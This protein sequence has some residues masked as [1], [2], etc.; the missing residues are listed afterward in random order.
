MALLNNIIEALRHWE[1]WRRIEGTP[2]R[3]DALERRVADLESKLKRS[4]GEACPACGELG[5]RVVR[6]E[7]MPEFAALGVRQHVLKCDACGFED[8]RTQ[9]PK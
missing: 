5:F 3:I 9:T 8:L 6:S 2:E 7:A 1:V 4:P